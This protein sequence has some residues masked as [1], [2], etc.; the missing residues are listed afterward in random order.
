MWRFKLSSEEGCTFHYDSSLMRRGVCVVGAGWA[1]G[2][3]DVAGLCICLSGQQPGR[4]SVHNRSRCC[5]GL[6][7]DLKLWKPVS[8]WLSWCKRAFLQTPS[9]VAGNIWCVSSAVLKSFTNLW[10][11]THQ[12]ILQSMIV[13]Y[14]GLLNNLLKV[15]LTSLA[16]CVHLWGFYILAV[17]LAHRQSASLR[18][19]A[20]GWSLIYFP[21]FIPSH[22]LVPTPRP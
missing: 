7:H 10:G 2:G 16:V 5:T 17:S 18:S 12:H 8:W 4:T 13:S 21:D 15:I 6:K 14:S 20:S 11:K 9:K 3:A 22:Q 19:V 1:A